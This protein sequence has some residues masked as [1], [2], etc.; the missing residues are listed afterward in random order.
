MQAIYTSLSY[1]SLALGC[2]AF[3]LALVRFTRLRQRVELPFRPIVLLWCV[4]SGCL[5]LGW[6][7][8]AFIGFYGASEY[9]GFAIV[10]GEGGL[11]TGREAIWKSVIAVLFMLA[12][13]MLL[14][15]SVRQNKWVAAFVI[16]ICLALR[17]Q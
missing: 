13:V 7:A 9:E 12:P 8:E 10:G 5:A 15:S 14:V 6:G 17:T 2:L 16:A 4:L 3:I 1:A 11:I